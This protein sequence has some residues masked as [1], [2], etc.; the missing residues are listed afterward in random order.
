VSARARF[1]GQVAVVTGGARGIGAAIARRLS[2]EGA[3]VYV[4]DVTSADG[5]DA[6]DIGDPTAVTAAMAQIVARHGRLDIGVNNAGITHRASLLDTTL[7]AWERVLRVNLTG[8]FLCSQAFARAMRE[9][10][11]A[12]VNMASISGQAGGSERAAYGAS[13][14]A[15]INLT[16]SMAVELAPY[17]I[18]VNAVSPGP[19]A[20]GMS[21]N[22]PAQQGV[23][24]GRMAM[25][26]FATPDEVAAAVAFL[27][28]P[29]AA[30]TTGHVLNVD[31]GFH[32]VGIIYREG[33]E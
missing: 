2:S 6:V 31:G 8:T 9:N 26:R 18:R 25:P 1:E 4:W 22:S 33:P 29:E 10:G 13:K 14:A 27:A 7:D 21:S 3:R 32:S 16:Q 11:G 24:F 12:I 5:A 20:T 19:T 30:M 15:I 17:G 28:S 23:S